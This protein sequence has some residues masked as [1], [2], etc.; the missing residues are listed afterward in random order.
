MARPEFS[1]WD[2]FEAWLD[3]KGLFHI[4]LG[5]GRI[6]SALK[7]CNLASLPFRAAQVLGTN[8]KGSTSA[9]LAGLGQAHGLKTGLYTSPHFLSPRERILI[10]G[11]QLHRQAWLEAVE[12]LGRQTDIAGLTYFE[13]LTLLAVSLFASNGVELAVFEAGLGGRNDAT[14]AINA[15]YLCFT[16]IAMDHANIIGPDLAAIAADKAATIKPGRRI[17]SAP[18]YPAARAALRNAA[19]SRGAAIAFAA[20]TP[21]KTG[22]AGS[23]QR[24]NAGVALAA[25]R[26]IAQDMALNPDGC[27][28]ARALEEAFVPGRLERIAE[29]PL[30]PEIILDGAH[31][32]HAIRQLLR[33][34]PQPPAAIIY[35][36][37][38]DKDWRSCLPMLLRATS[39]LLIP[40]LDNSRA[41]NAGEMAAF[42]NRIAPQSC[43][44]TTNLASALALLQK[45]PALVCGSFYLLAEF[46]KLHSQSAERIANV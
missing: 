16:P 27:K 31:N 8:G 38:A 37:L 13:L 23:H 44:A 5:L 7:A 1:S 26:R 10:D 33:S 41:E 9:F 34:L 36:A 3:S 30:H 14:T 19:K 18:Q 24:V 20:P 2:Q 42:A 45:G 4:E 22:L 21:C 29:T 39:C 25:W 32:P 15:D 28:E 35:S 12:R 6:A 40:Q 11:R 43:Q 46:Y 17:F